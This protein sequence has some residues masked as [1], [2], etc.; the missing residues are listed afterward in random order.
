MCDEAFTD[1]YARRGGDVAAPIPEVPEL[2]EIL[3]RADAAASV[4]HDF[5]WNRNGVTQ[6]EASDAI[7]LVHNAL[8]PLFEDDP[9]PGET[10]TIC[11]SCGGPMDLREAIV[12]PNCGGD[13][14]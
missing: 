9:E 7:W 14:Q 8:R 5:I 10:G 2:E 4:A 13:P 12:C 1:E 3:R 11:M 6:Q